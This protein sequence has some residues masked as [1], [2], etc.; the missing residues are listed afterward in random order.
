[1]HNS[2]IITSGVDT[3]AAVLKANFLPF[4]K[5]PGRER[6]QK[7]FGRAVDMSCRDKPDVIANDNRK[8]ENHMRAIDC[9]LSVNM[10]NEN[11]T[12]DSS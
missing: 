11:S 8:V 1:M 6:T 9:P 4:M 5:S 10:M 12:S 7:V 2:G 3:S